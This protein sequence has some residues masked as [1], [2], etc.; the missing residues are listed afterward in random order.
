MRLTLW[1]KHAEQYN[2]TDQPVIAFKSVRVGDFGGKLLC[3]VSLSFILLNS[4][5]SGRS[6]SMI[7][8][9]L[10]AINPDIPEAHGLRGW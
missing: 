9:S 3:I 10:M 7:S 2:A 4:S 5:S 8:S 6:L 1:G